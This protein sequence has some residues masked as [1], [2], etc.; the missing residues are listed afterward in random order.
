M[1][2]RREMQGRKKEGT[3][4]G[5]RETHGREEKLQTQGRECKG[6][7]ERGTNGDGLV[8]ESNVVC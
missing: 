7:Q 2:E 3:L 1:R 6:L 8:W 4:R 5:E